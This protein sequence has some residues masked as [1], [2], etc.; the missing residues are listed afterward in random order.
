MTSP[1]DRHPASGSKRY[2]FAAGLVAAIVALLIVGIG[3]AIALDDSDDGSPAA[4]APTTEPSRAP[5]PATPAAVPD[6]RFGQDAPIPNGTVTALE[7]QQEFQ[8]IGAAPA[9]NRWATAMVRSCT[10]AGAQPVTAAS[11]DWVLLDS[12]GGRYPSSRTGNDDFPRPQY[13]FGWE[14]VPAG[15]CVEGWVVFPVAE[16]VTI[17]RVRYAPTSGGQTYG[18]W[19][20]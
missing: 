15:E 4:A 18:T 10:T 7:V 19:A 11:A 12:N 1:N 14:A 9:G 16:G 13:P 6:L 5:A 8:S 3:I 2:G 17:E 20:S